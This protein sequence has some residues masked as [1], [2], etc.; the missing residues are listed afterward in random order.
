MAEVAN[1]FTDLLWGPSGW[2]S[3]NVMYET[4]RR[5]QCLSPLGITERQH[6]I[7]LIEKTAA[8]WRHEQEQG[9]VGGT[10]AYHIGFALMRASYLNARAQELLKTITYSPRPQRW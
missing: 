6:V 3:P 4:L 2:Q 10:L 8:E 1:A 7:G 9:M 5:E